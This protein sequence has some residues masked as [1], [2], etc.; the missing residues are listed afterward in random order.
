MNTGGC[1]LSIF[2]ILHKSKIYLFLPRIIQYGKY[3]LTS[4]SP[5]CL[6]FYMLVES[7]PLP[8]NFTQP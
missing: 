6:S 3:G 2:R 5:V 1:Y 4:A 7:W 8:K